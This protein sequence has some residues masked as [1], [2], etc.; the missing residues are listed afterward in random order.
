MNTHT[1]TNPNKLFI[2]LLEILKQERI[3]YTHKQMSIIIGKPPQR[4]SDYIAGRYRI[5]LPEVQLIANAFGKYITVQ[6]G[7]LKKS[8]EMI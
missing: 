2:A 6:Y 5:T 3:D 8:T 7:I 4:I 1:Y